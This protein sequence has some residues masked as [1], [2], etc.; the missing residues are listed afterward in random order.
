MVRM[1]A[2]SVG[3]ERAGIGLLVGFTVG[4]FSA[5][6]TL[7]GVVEEHPIKTAAQVKLSNLKSNFTLLEVFAM[8]E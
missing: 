2:S 1:V 3:C 8:L 5:S 6:V 4:V 7:V